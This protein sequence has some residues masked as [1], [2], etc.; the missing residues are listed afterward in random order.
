V[1]RERERERER[2]EYTIR[3]EDWMRNTQYECTVRGDTPIH[4][5]RMEYARR[6]RLIP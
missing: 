1:L 4:A 2:V 6:N 5:V 3:S